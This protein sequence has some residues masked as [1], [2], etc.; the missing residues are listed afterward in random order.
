MERITTVRV[1]SQTSS[2]AP[3]GKNQKP[4]TGDQQWAIL[5]IST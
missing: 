5:A 4:I 1:R 3:Y 2:H